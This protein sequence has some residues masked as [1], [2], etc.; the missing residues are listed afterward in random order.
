MTLEA[1]WKPNLVNYTVEYY[2]EKMDGSYDMETETRQGN[3][4]STT[5]MTAQPKEGYTA[6]PIEQQTVA[7][8]GSTV[9]KVYYELN[10]YQ[11]KFHDRFSET[12]EK[13]YRHGETITAPHVA[14]EGYTFAYWYSDYG[15]NAFRRG[16][17]SH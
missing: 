5:N 3:T 8:D 6:K 2:T 15:T 12:Y 9:V 16:H 13:T 17:G 10:T 1:H 7:A 14:K 11:V 4:D